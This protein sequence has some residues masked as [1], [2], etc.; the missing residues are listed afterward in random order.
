MLYFIASWTVLLISCS[1]IGIALLNCLGENFFVRVGDRLMAAEWL[2]MIALSIC[3]LAVSLV[4]PLSSLIGILVVVTLCGISFISK[5]TRTEV[6]AL[7]KVSSWQLVLSYIGLAIAVA[8]FTNQQVTWIDTGL[9]HYSVIQWLHNY[10]TVTG[11]AL[12][13]SNL[14]FT[15]SWFALAAPFN[16][17]SLEARVSAVTNGFVFLLAILHFLVCLRHSIAGKALFSDWFVIVFLGLMLPFT[18][19]YTLFREI[20]ISPSPDL[21]TGLLIGIVCWA[22]LVVTNLQSPILP[23]SQSL[24]NYN[25]QAVPLIL[26]VGALTIKLTAMPLMLVTSLFYAVHHR[27]SIQKLCIGGAIALVLLAP[28]LAAGIKTSGCPLYP[29][30]I[31]CLDLPWLPDAENIDQ[32]A[33]GTHGWSNWYGKPPEGRNRWLWLLLTWLNSERPN[34]AMVALIIATIV[35]MIMTFKSF[36][37]IPIKGKYWIVAIEVVGFLFLM[38]TAPFFRFALPYLLLIP[39][40]LIAMYAQSLLSQIVSIVFRYSQRSA[41][42]FSL[43]FIAAVLTIFT[44]THATSQ[45]LLPPAM[46]RVPVI[47]RRVNDIV[48]FYPQNKELCWAT[49]LPCGFEIEPDVRLRDRER[50]IAGGFVYTKD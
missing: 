34:Q 42:A 3:L 11:V 44:Q 38:M 31:L 40:L 22:I 6:G 10:G 37:K 16:P 4:L 24:H 29:S 18:L 28:M 33:Q 7:L 27:R 47:Q 1:V 43:V 20:L 23:D 17:A 25:A 21:P 48:Y 39:S 12:I 8:A 2:G 45:W 36:R 30:S 32:V 19:L 5:R 13:F 15:S 46:Q 9:Y 35:G 26:S 49:E 41:I 14:G 50:G